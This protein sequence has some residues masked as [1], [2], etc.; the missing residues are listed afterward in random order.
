M[1]NR[2][3]RQRSPQIPPRKELVSYSFHE[4]LPIVSTNSEN[5]R[6]VVLNLQIINLLSVVRY[7]FNSKVKFLVL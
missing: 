4:G 1:F 7:H 6:F 2:V 5:V 3:C